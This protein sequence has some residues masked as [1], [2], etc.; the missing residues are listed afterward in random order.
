MIGAMG[1]FEPCSA[2]D[3][4]ISKQ[5]NV[6][7]ISNLANLLEQRDTVQRQIDELRIA[8]RDRA[9]AEARKL[10]DDHDLTVEDLAPRFLQVSRESR[11]VAPKYRDPVTGATWTGRGLKPRW[12]AAALSA[13]KSLSDFSL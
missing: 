7:M 4:S 3:L 11:A 2:L 8:S 1:F 13:G 5:L 12:L 6:A 10:M 9:I